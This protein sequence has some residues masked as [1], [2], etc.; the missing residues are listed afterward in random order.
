MVRELGGESVWE[1]LH[2]E[3]RQEKEEEILTRVCKSLGPEAF[4]RLPESEQHHLKI[5]VWVGCGMHKDLNA[6]KGGDSAMRQK[7]KELGVSPIPLPNKDNAAV[8]EALDDGDSDNEDYEEFE[9]A[10]EPVSEALSAAML[11]R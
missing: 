4:K 7:W 1:A 2:G 5:W 11:H 9:Q 8:L 10:E 3:E 6:V